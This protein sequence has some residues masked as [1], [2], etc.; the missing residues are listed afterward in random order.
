[1][2]WFSDVIESLCQPFRNGGT[3][4]G[5]LAVVGIIGTVTTIALAVYKI[6][7]IVQDVRALVN[8]TDIAAAIAAAPIDPVRKVILGNQISRFAF[9]TIGKIGSEI[10]RTSDWCSNSLGTFFIGT[11]GE[12]I[13]PIESSIPDF[14]KA[15]SKA[16]E[17][18]WA[19]L[20]CFFLRSSSIRRRAIVSISAQSL[21]ETASRKFKKYPIEGI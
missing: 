15:T 21:L 12:A 3:L 6:Y 10:S 5:T 9:S 1:M 4:I 18:W 14:D 13:V 8:L 17:I 7:T 20:K 2:L 19:A 11:K 16:S